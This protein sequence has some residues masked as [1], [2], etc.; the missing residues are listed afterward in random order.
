MKQ[1][2]IAAALTAVVGVASAASSAQEE[3]GGWGA[4]H[5]GLQA[6]LCVQHTRM[7][8]GGAPI[9]VL[10]LKF[11]RGAADKDTRFLCQYLD[12]RHVTMVFTNTATNRKY[13]RIPDDGVRGY[14]P[15]P[16]K[17]DVSVMG[18]GVKPVQLPVHLMND[19]GEIVPAGTYTVVASYRNEGKP[20][21]I[22]LYKGGDELYDGPWHFWTGR[23]ESAPLTVTVVD[24]GG[25]GKQAKI[26]AEI[27]L[28][29]LGGI[30]WL[31]SAKSKEV[32]I[33]FRAGYYI[34]K[35]YQMR[36]FLNG[37]EALPCGYGLSAKTFDEGDDMGVLPNNVVVRARSGEKLKLQADITIFETSVQPPED[38]SWNPMG[39]A[40]RELWKGS[41]EGEIPPHLEKTLQTLDM[42]L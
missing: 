22:N 21:I 6:A 24:V 32:P 38:G 23:I 12:A 5:D 39:G 29:L 27:E 20:E 25:I 30:G 35:R 11:D 3:T 13:E 10:R 17:E 42:A 16:V 1:A 8:E 34:G 4:A 37:E 36:Y 31:W 40:Y 28:N 26:N 18:R 33:T 9:F 15:D 41:V 14:P 2:I 19:N 7:A